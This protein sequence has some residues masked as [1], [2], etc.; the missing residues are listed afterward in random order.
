[1]ISPGDTWEKQCMHGLFT[2]CILFLVLGGRI[3][4]DNLSAPSIMLSRVKTSHFGVEHILKCHLNDWNCETVA[5][6]CSESYKLKMV[7][8][9]P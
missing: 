7:S 9:C 2:D 8:L 4:L 6:F 3:R 1:M 5:V